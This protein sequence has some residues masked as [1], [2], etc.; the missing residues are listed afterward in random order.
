MCLWGGGGGGGEGDLTPSVK[1]IRRN[2]HQNCK[3]LKVSEIIIIIYLF[4]LS[5]RRQIFFKAETAFHCSGDMA[6]RMS[7]GISVAFNNGLDLK[8]KTANNTKITA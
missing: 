2:R 8:I 7:K 5:I 1:N 3:H 6:V 4:I